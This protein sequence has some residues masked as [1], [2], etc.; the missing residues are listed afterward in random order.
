MGNTNPSSILITPTECEEFSSISKFKENEIVH[1]FKHFENISKS[2]LDDGV[3]DYQEFI[4]C[5]GIKD[6]LVS[7]QMFKLLDMNHDGRINFREFVMGLNFLMEEDQKGIS[8]ILFKLFD[9][10]NRKSFGV[11]EILIIL[12]SCID[13]FKYVK[14]SSQMLKEIVINNLVEFRFDIRNKLEEPTLS[15]QSVDLLRKVEI[16]LMNLE[17]FQ[18]DE[19]TFFIYFKL[20]P[21]TLKWLQVDFELIRQNASK[22]VKNGAI[23]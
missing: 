18:F 17:E 12:Q 10:Y 13:Q 4:N 2:Q 19:E 16:N 3:I 14:I 15:H 9:V 1:L 6:S 20:A 23:F 21:L 11:E 7:K 8:K 22:M 5:L